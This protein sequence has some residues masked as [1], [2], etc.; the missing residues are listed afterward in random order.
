MIM[1]YDELCKSRLLLLPPSLAYANVPIAS[2]DTVTRKLQGLARAVQ[3]I[4]VGRPLCQRDLAVFRD[5][6]LSACQSQTSCLSD[7]I[8]HTLVIRISLPPTA[9]LFAAENM[10][11]GVGKRV[12][13]KSS[14]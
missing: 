8:Y 5:D 11:I 1:R 12:R 7:T 4:V 2:Q 14:P 6:I 13:L 9:S 3:G 10:I